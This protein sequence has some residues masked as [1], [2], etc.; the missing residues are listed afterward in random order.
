MNIRSST[1]LA[2]LA[3]AVL[4]SALSFAGSARAS[5]MD[6]FAE[7]PASDDVAADMFAER[8]T[9]QQGATPDRAGENF[10]DD[11]LP[12]WKREERSDV[13]ERV[14]QWRRETQK[15]CASRPRA[16]LGLSLS[17]GFRCDYG[18]ERSGYSCA[19]QERRY[20]ERRRANRKRNAAIAAERRAKREAELRRWIAICENFDPA[21]SF[22]DPS[23]AARL[24]EI[25]ADLARYRR[26]NAKEMSATSGEFQRQQDRIDD[27][28]E[29]AAYEEENA[30]IARDAQMLADRHAA[31]AARERQN[32]ELIDSEFEASCRESLVKGKFIS[33]NC[34]IALGLPKSTMTDRGVPVCQQ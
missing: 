6:F 4:A 14:A 12:T 33:C 17:V 22:P 31:A 25:D 7:R 15:L 29:A 23:L 18:K 28:T 19:A 3:A 32:R 5:D 10:F 20:D 27:E 16:P 2:A 26:D 9:G 34:S 13:E 1:F 11:V 21:S 24:A 30:R 8:P